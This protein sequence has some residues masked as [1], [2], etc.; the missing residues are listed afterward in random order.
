MFFIKKKAIFFI[1][2]LYLS[3]CFPFFCF[4][5]ALAAEG[6]SGA[7]GA[8]LPNFLGEG[9]TFPTLLERIVDFLL[10]LAGPFAVIMV[11]WAAFLYITSSGN[12][13]RISQAHKVILWTVV[14]VGVLVL[15]K[16]LISLIV[17]ILGGN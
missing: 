17:D 2:A 10:T 3:F 16:G 1:S 4:N 11:L 14:G 5:S 8:S 13:N 6:S 12:A 9:A 7:G 15:S